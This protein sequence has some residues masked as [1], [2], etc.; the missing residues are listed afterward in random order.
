M[1]VPLDA[2]PPEDICKALGIT[3]RKLLALARAGKIPSVRID[4]KTTVFRR[5]KIEAF[6]KN[7][8][9]PAT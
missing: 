4:R 3:R 8:E 6:L 1:S 7:R 9:E 2:I 5:S